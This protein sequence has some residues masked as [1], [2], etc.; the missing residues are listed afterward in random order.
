MRGF[1][2]SSVV[3]R[4]E[5]PLEGGYQPSEALVVFLIVVWSAAGLAVTPSRLLDLPLTRRGP[6]A[7]SQRTHHLSD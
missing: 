5:S 1:G 2:C 3:V 7:S 4:T 6:L